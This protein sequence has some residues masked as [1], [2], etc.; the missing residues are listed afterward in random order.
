VPSAVK[1]RPRP[2]WLS[3]GEGTIKSR[4]SKPYAAKKAALEDDEVRL[5]LELMEEAMVA[6]PDNWAH[7]K[8]VGDVIWDTSEPGLA[9]AS[10]I[11]N[12][13]IVFL[14]FIDLFGA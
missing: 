8:Q 13:E 7:R 1:L 10:T 5:S 9:L 14:T 12:D 2:R 4:P 6:E 11:D 3:S